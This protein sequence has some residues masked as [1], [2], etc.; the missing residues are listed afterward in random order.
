MRRLLVKMGFHGV[1]HMRAKIWRDIRTAN[2][3][4]MAQYW[5]YQ[6]EHGADMNQQWRMK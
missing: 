1:C 5:F 6:G 3:A 4:S 2:R